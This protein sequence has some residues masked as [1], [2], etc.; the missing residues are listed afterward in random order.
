[1]SVSMAET[2][3]MSR[4]AKPFYKDLSILVLISIGVGTALGASDPALGIAMQPLG[5]VFI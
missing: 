1:M 2:T 4:K 3:G 5:T